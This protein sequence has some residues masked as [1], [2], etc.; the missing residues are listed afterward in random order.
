[1]ITE[2]R[3]TE[4]LRTISDST[5][6]D[7]AIMELLAEIKLGFAEMLSVIEGFGTIGDDGIFT[8]TELD[9][10][11][12]WEVKYNALR[13]LYKDRFFDTPAKEAGIEAGAEAD[14]EQDTPTIDELLTIKED[15]KDA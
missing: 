13:E 10:P 1:M 12:E 5:Q 4:M 14:V 7:S 9:E 8:P 2:P 15:K 6:L 3:L 11:N